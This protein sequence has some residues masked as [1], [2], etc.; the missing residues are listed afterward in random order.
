LYYCRADPDSNLTIRRGNSDG[1]IMATAETS[2]AVEGSTEIYFHDS[3]TSIEIHHT[4]SRLPFVYCK[5]LF[6]YNGKAYH[7]KDHKELVDDATGEVVGRFHTMWLEGS[8]RRIGTLEVLKDVRM[9]DMVV[10]TAI[11]VQ[12]R[13][14][15]RNQAVLIRFCHS[16]NRLKGNG[17]SSSIWGFERISQRQHFRQHRDLR[18]QSLNCRSIV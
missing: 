16:N 10:I 15:E 8:G 7:W 4:H 5:T 12:E 1:P 13:S 2:K 9:Q 14:D 17:T 18:L 11:V 6:T 3:G